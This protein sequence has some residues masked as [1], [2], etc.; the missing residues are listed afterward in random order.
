MSKKKEAERQLFIDWVATPSTLKDIKT[1]KEFSEEFAIDEST[2]SRWKDDDDFW[3]E[4]RVRIKKWAK[5]K[6]PNVVNAIYRG[7]TDVGESGQ[8]ANAKL[9]L[10][11]VDDWSE[12]IKVDN[13][14]EEIKQIADGLQNLYSDFKEEVDKL[15]EK[16]K[17]NKPKKS[18]D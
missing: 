16:T 17:T 10:Q 9:W 2:L 4:V 18:K 7:A 13:D 6:T 11:W 12:T 8:S 5:A 14:N 3:D 15:G 1:Q